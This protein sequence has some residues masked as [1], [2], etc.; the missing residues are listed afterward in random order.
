MHQNIESFKRQHMKL[1]HRNELTLK[2]Y[3][4]SLYLTINVTLTALFRVLRYHVIFKALVDPLGIKIFAWKFIYSPILTNGKKLDW[5][6]MT[7]KIV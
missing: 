4:I 2:N 6:Q 7:K 3:N 5:V 1:K